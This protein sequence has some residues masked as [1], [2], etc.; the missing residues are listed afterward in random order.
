M[1]FLNY[2]VLYIM[3]NFHSFLKKLDIKTLKNENHILKAENA[4]FLKTIN[5]LKEELRLIQNNSSLSDESIKALENKLH[6]SVENLV[7]NILDN[8]SINSSLIPDFIERKIYT[9]V[10]TILISIMK[11]IIEDTNIN[12]LNQKI[13]LNMSANNL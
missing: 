9:N 5:K 3:G 6:I 2:Y 13:T 7:N 1:D 4:L 8:E 12:I 11:E 10:F